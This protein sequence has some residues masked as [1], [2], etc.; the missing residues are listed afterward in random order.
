MYKN[1]KT[2]IAIC[3]KRSVDVVR[4]M[5]KNGDEYMNPSVFSRAING[6]DRTPRYVKVREEADRIVT[7]WER[8][9]G[10]EPFLG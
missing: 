3:G 2:R 10:R 9:Q 7:E 4:E 6:A 8:E 5:I 1:L